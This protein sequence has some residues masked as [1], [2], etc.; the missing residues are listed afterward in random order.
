[1]K[2]ICTYNDFDIFTF[3]SDL[4]HIM[5]TFDVICISYVGFK[6]DCWSTETPLNTR[7]SNQVQYCT[8][9]LWLI[10]APEHT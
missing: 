2:Y 8:R 5:C 1:M 9:L 4:V 6:S 10:G 3:I 7:Y